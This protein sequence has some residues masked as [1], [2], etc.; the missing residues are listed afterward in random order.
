MNLNLELFTYYARKF[1]TFFFD[2]DHESQ[3]II[4]HLPYMKIYHIFSFF[5]GIAW[6]EV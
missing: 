2:H 1:I 5:N 3:P 6:Q 4:I